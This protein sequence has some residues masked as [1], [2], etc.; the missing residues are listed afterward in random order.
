MTFLAEKVKGEGSEWVS[1]EFA[2]SCGLLRLG[3]VALNEETTVTKG[4][5]GEVK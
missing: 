3:P 5:K 1:D 4:R 2:W